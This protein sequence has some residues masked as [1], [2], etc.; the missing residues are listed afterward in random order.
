MNRERVRAEARRR[1][2]D[3]PAIRSKVAKQGKAYRE[4]PRREHVLARKREYRLKHIEAT[5]ARIRAWYEAKGRLRRIE[6][7][8]EER[9]SSLAA[10]HR[11]VA[12]N[13]LEPERERNRVWREKN[14]ARWRVLVNNA[15]NRRRARLA[16]VGNTLTADEWLTILAVFDHRC[17]YCLRG[18]VS[19]QQDHVIAISRGGAHTEENVVP[20]C[21]TCNSKKKDRP[22][23]VMV[24]LTHVPRAGSRMD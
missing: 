18:G 24:N 1:Y 12:L 3:D 8:P 23:W 13:G 2:A 11:R 19:L 14:Y 15:M 4:G 6:K 21:K 20:A 7:R 17:A 9:R 10:Y 16:V 5:K 22:V